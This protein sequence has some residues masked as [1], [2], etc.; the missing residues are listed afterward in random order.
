F[1]MADRMRVTSLIGS[2]AAWGSLTY[3]DSVAEVIRT[4]YRA[5]RGLLRVA[6]DLPV[7]WTGREI[8]ST[9]GP[10]IETYERSNAT[11]TSTSGTRSRDGGTERPVEVAAPSNALGGRCTARSAA[12]IPFM[13]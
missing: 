4:N 3:S 9:S 11:P 2:S 13:K 7:S 6:S 5:A 1:S 8:G 10:A 12:V